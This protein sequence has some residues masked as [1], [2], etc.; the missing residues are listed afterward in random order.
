MARWHSFKSKNEQNNKRYEAASKKGN[1][2]CNCLKFKNF[3]HIRK[4]TRAV[5]EGIWQI[6]HLQL[7]GS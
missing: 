5:V 4:I 2:Y 1:I 6:K 3:R 7:K